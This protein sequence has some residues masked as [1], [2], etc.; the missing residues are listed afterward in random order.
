ML[1]GGGAGLREIKA[2]KKWDS[3]NSIINKIYL[4]IEDLSCPQF[5]YKSL[6]HYSYNEKGISIVKSVT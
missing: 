3:Y 4:K 1:E 2:R 5:S 6:N